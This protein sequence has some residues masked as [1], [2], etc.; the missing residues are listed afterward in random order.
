MRLSIYIRY[1][2]GVSCILTCLCLCVCVVI[3]TRVS[4]SFESCCDR[5]KKKEEM[6]KFSWWDHRILVTVRRFILLYSII[7]S[8]IYIRIFCYKNRLYVDL[9]T[10]NGISS[11]GVLIKNK[12]KK[13]WTIELLT[14]VFRT[15]SH[16]YRTDLIRELFSFPLHSFAFTSFLRSFHFSASSFLSFFSFR[17]ISSFFILSFLLSLSVCFVYLFLSI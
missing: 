15:F 13:K 16:T 10:Y 6:K 8:T 14:I 7:S 12:K 1:V 17:S 3:Y 11:K 4:F 5:Y 2:L 9:F